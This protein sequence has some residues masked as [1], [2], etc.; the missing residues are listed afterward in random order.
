MVP[1]SWS[2]M[3]RCSR[4]ILYFISHFQNQLQ[5]VLI[6][7]GIGEFYDTPRSGP[8]GCWQLGSFSFQ[9]QL[10]Y[11]YG[12]SVGSLQNED[13]RSNFITGYCWGSSRECVCESFSIFGLSLQFLNCFLIRQFIDS[14]I[15]FKRKQAMFFCLF[16]CFNEQTEMTHHFRSHLLLSRPILDRDS[17]C[18]CMSATLISSPCTLPP[19]CSKSILGIVSQPCLCR[20]D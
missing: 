5:W 8:L 19:S 6:Q 15:A 4:L 13:Q 7:W 17:L 14:I 9:V 12:A 1:Y 11:L 2:L 16:V 18:I 20:K 10:Q 3:T